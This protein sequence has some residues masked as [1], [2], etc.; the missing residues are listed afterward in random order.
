MAQQLQSSSSIAPEEGMTP[1]QVGILQLNS[2]S[3]RSMPDLSV[4]IQRNVQSTFC[5]TQQNAPGSTGVFVVQ[6]GSSY[7]NFLQSSLVIDVQNLSTNGT[8]AGAGSGMPVYK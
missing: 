6:S 3:F 8:G 2:L 7:V 1:S 5:Q 4:S